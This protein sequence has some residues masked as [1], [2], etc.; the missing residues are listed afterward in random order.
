M[1]EGVLAATVVLCSQETTV[2]LDLDTFLTAGY[3]TVDELYQGS[4][5]D[6]E[7]TRRGKRAE[8]SDSEVLTLA[9][10]A[11]WP[12]RRSAAAVLR[13]AS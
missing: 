4:L 2:E 7:P 10:L 9:I 6:R 8:R 3:V 5:A 12:G 1:R 11:Q 13:H